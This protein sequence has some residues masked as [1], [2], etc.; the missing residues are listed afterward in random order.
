[1]NLTNTTYL[2][3]SRERKFSEAEK[4]ASENVRNCFFSSPPGDLHVG[5]CVG[6]PEKIPY[7]EN[8]LDEDGHHQDD[9]DDQDDYQDG[10]DDEEDH[11]GQEGWRGW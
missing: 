5:R 6:W 10:Q 1:M 4:I 2:E 8:H 3:D 9:K 7:E 11:D